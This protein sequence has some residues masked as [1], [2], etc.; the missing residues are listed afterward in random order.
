[1][2]DRVLN[3]TGLSYR[4]ATG[5]SSSLR[6]VSLDIEPGEFVVVAGRSG[7]GKTSLLRAAC[8][9]IPHFHGGEFS[10]LVE[11]AGRDTREAGPGEL[12]DVAGYVA[13]DPETQI[14]STT[15]ASELEL[16]LRFRGDPPAARARAVEEVALALNIPHLLPRSVATLSGGEMQRVA[17]AVALVTRPPLVLLDEPTSQLDP[18]AGDELIWLLR[19]LNEEW[20][21]AVVLAEHRLERCLAAA[22][23]VVTMEAGR[24]SFDGPPRD[25]LEFAVGHDPALATPAARMFEMAGIDPLPVGVRDARATLRVRGLTPTAGGAGPADADRAGGEAR[26]NGR[27]LR[28]RDLWVELDSGEGPRDVLRGIDLELDP[29]ERVALMGRN[30][31]GKSTLLRTAA[32]LLE[33]VSGSVSARGGMALLTQNPGDFLVRDRVGDELP[34]PEGEAALAAAGLGHLPADAD[35]R[36]LSGGE[37]QRLAL[38]I[39]LAGRMEGEALPDLIALDEPTRGM[40]RELKDSLA[41]LADRLAARGAAVLISTHDVEFAVTFAD[42]VVLLGDGELIADADTGSV[43][44]GGWYFASETARVLGVGGVTRVEDG[45]RLLMSGEGS[46]AP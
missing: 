27:A 25:M 39:A 40:D 9:L 34:G 43:L 38:A 18:V 11:V 20:G 8:G 23:R 3:V 24:I 6:D 5:T 42:R 36:D 31:A 33:P 16:P 44:S 10:G 26:R 19:R 30:G 45:A 12:A 32:G 22:D 46:L 7:S 41:V 4:Y 17:L 14:I 29:G 15:V 28:C 1:M 37:R 35:P 2:A 21:V 13:Q